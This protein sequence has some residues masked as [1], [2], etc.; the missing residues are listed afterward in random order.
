MHRKS[1]LIIARLR[2][3][4]PLVSRLAS[5]SH[6]DNNNDNGDDE[7]TCDYDPDDDPRIVVHTGHF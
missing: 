7:N 3:Y 6:A 4:R 1:T 5:P 2:F